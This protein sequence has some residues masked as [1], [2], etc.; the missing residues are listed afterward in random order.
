MLKS[1]EIYIIDGKNKVVQNASERKL[2][3]EGVWTNKWERS[4]ESR[5]DHE[6]RELYKIS[7]LSVHIKMINLEWMNHIIR[8]YQTKMVKKIFESTAVGR[9]RDWRTDSESF[10][11]GLG[12]EAVQQPTWA[13]KR[14][15]GLPD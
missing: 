7:D 4:L 9:R 14:Q 8:Q 6:L 5:N 13:W 12:I 2:L 15:A 1:G 11:W 10:A 3:K